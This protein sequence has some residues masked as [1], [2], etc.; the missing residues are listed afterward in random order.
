[1]KRTTRVAIPEPILRLQK[2]LDEFRAGH[3]VR[4]KLP[5]S[6]WQ[7]ATEL[8]RQY[9]VYAV[10]HPLRL[11]HTGLSRRVHPGPAAPK[12][13]SFRRGCVGPQNLQFL[14]GQDAADG[15]SA[16]IQL[17]GDLGFADT[18]AGQPAGSGSHRGR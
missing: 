8:A 14:S 17:S 9:G 2:Q 1:M 6:L 4:T 16:D 10:A 5:E 11:D 7:A 15:R 13:V 18:V 12:S 3:R